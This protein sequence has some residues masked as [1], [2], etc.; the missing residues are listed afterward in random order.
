MKSIT[1]RVPD[2]EAAMLAELKRKYNSFKS[3]ET[4]LILDIRKA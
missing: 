4:M 3:I 1:I 2:V